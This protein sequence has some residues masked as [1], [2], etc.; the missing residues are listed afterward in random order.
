MATLDFSIDTTWNGGAL[1][2]TPVKF[3]L[4]TSA[5]QQYL[6]FNITAPFFNDPPAPPGTPGQPFYGLWD[7]EVVEAFFL[8]N[9]NQYLEVEVCPWGQHIVLLLSGQRITVRHSLQ[10]KVETDIGVNTWTGSAAIPVTYLPERVT[11]FNAYA[12]HGSGA[13]RVYESLYPAPSTA[14]NPDF[15]ALEYFK[16]I[17]LSSILPTQAGDP[18]SQLWMDSL[19]GLFRYD[20]A[21]TWNDLPL[22]TPRVEIT[23]QGFEAGVEMNVTAPFYN[24]PAPPGT[25]G[26]PFY[27][28]WDYEV[29]EMFFLNKNDEYLEVELGPWGQHLL[30]LLQGERNPI[31]HSLA[32][33]YII[34]ERTDPVGNQPGRWKGSAM[35]PP[36]YFPPNVTLMNS[37]AIHGTGKDR[38]YQALYPAPHDDP[39]YPNPDF[40]RLDLFRAIDFEFQVKDNKDY[41]QVWLDAMGSTT[42]PASED[43]APTLSVPET[44]EVMMTS[45]GPLS[46]TQTITPEPETTDPITSEP[47]DP[48]T[49]QPVGPDTTEPVN[50]AGLQPTDH[51]TVEE[52]NVII[53]D[54]T[55]LREITNTEKTEP[56][57][58]IPRLA[59]TVTPEPSETIPED[60]TDPVDTNPTEAASQ[61][62]TTL[63]PTTPA[64]TTLPEPLEA[65][66][67]TLS[68]GKLRTAG[69]RRPHP[70][71][72]DTN[73]QTANIASPNQPDRPRRRRP[74]PTPSQVRPNRRVVKQKLPS[75]QGLPIEVNLSP[76]DAFI[77]QHILSRQN[78]GFQN[79][80]NQARRNQQNQHQQPFPRDQ[81]PS[82]SIGQQFQPP[83]VQQLQPPRDQQ[84]QP[85]RDEQFQPPRDEQFQPPRDEQFQPPRDEQFQYPRDEQFQP[86]RDEQFQPPRDEQFQPPR[87]EQFQPPRD[88]QFQPPRDEQFQPP[89][90]EQFQPPRD[91]QFQPPRDE[92]FQPP[93]DEQFQP[94]RDEQFQPPRDEQFQPP[95]DEQ[96][97]PPRDEQFQPPRDEQFQP[98]RDQQ[99]QPPRRQ[100]FQPPRDEQFQ[101]PRGQQFQPPRDQQFQPPRDQQFQP[102]RDEQFQPPRDEHFSTPKKQKQPHRRPP[103]AEEE[104]L[105][106]SRE[107]EAPLAVEEEIGIQEVKEVIASLTEGE[108]ALPPPHPICFSPGLVPDEH[109]CWVFHECELVDGQWQ[110]YSWKCIRG[111]VYDPFNVACV[112]GRCRRRG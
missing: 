20:I 22:P 94:P 56:T 28:L 47:Q 45:L 21:T 33:D 10:M 96:F 106:P 108:A 23:L 90:D 34:T 19:Q 79:A 65:S 97:Q 83:R 103:S 39:L 74:V 100:Q 44:E 70:Q 42:T 91:E 73:Q 67:P 31:R 43:A 60:T 25:P 82:A 107:G 68:P 4:S 53:L 1:D 49:H 77:V 18:M 95:R 69:H 88:E 7:Y 2:H 29:V 64:P 40:H 93:R 32:L 5:D 6:F 27:G 16:P 75:L 55:I 80:N 81:E 99:F 30:L 54:D 13:D 48:A 14:P 35:I 58:F 50:R 46:A 71:R 98:P 41:S 11:L 8:N 3:S 86:P 92:E 66:T 87:D 111:H 52:K 61:D 109:R 57:T 59:N 63:P 89:R 62:P 12:I 36:G 37:Y 105:S 24:D 101:P 84:F 9:A 110:V 17:D 72:V 104:Q 102:P 15:H 112:P 51:N 76:E 38:Q 26:K 78:L 85:P